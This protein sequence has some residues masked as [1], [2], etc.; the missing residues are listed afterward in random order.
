MSYWSNWANWTIRWEAGGWS[1]RNLSSSAHTGSDRTLHEILIRRRRVFAGEVEIAFSGFLEAAEASGLAYP[2]VSVG[3]PE[4]LVEVAVGVPADPR[5]GFPR[6]C[7]PGEHWLERGQLVADEFRW[8][9]PMGLDQPVSE[10]QRCPGA[11]A[12]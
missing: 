12:G 11:P 10:G 4:V 8:R 6:R 9:G 3:A 5:P 7:Q 2:V 1:G